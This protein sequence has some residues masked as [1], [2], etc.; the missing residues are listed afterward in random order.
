MLLNRKYWATWKNI[1]KKSYFRDS[2]FF[3]HKIFR[4]LFQGLK[5]EVKSIVD[6]HVLQTSIVRARKVLLLLS[7]ILQKAC[8]YQISEVV[9]AI[10]VSVA[11]RRIS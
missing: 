2:P 3:G 9:K 6:Y 11:G 5:F 7:F 4:Q 10:W 8:A 1:D